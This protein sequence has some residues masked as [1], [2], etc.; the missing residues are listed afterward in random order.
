MSESIAG[1]TGGL[2]IRGARTHNLKNIDLDLPANALIV[3]TGVSGSGK[4]SLA[5]DTV[6]AEGQRRYVESL[7]AY[8]RQF[9]ERMEKPDVDEI[10][11]VSPAIAIRQKNSIRNPRSTVGTTTE[12]HDYLRLLYARVGRTFCRQCGQEVVRESA[13]VVARRLAALPEGTRLIIGFDM[14]VVAGPKAGADNGADPADEVTEAVPP[15]AN[16]RP[17]R[18]TRA[19]ARPTRPEMRP[20]FREPMGARHGPGVGHDRR[21]PPQGVRPAAHRDGRAAVSFDEVEPSL[22]GNRALLQVVVDRLVAGP[23]VLTRLTDSIETAYGEGGGAAFA[24]EL[25]PE[26]RRRLH[27]FSERFECRACGIAYE[28]P[29][30]RLFSFNNPFGACPT[31]HGFGNVIELD[32]DLVVPDPSRSINDNAIEPWSKPHYRSSLADL[33]RAARKQGV[34]LDVPWADL[35]EDERRFVVEGDGEDYEGDPRLLRLAGAEEVQ[36][37][38]PRVPEP[39]PRLPDVPGLRR[40]AAA[41]RGA[42]RARRRPDDRPGVRADRARGAALL[43]GAVA[44]R[45]GGGHRRRRCSP[46]SAAAWRSSPRSASTTSRS[47]AC[48][49]RSRAASRSASTW[50]PRSARRWSARCTCWTSRRSASTRATTCA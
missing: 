41:A 2:V 17:V 37:P 18:R 9:L 16:R 13:E 7:S 14:P 34:R 50:P 27:V 43:P 38:R 28:D 25:P 39:V 31:C 15:T 36:G 12:I 5:F 8:A 24:V 1:A 30:P 48:R 10:D 32:M 44:G 33:K 22:L 42:R 19:R 35:T 45:A 6:Y 47:I 20:P 3:V 49:P 4:S 23:D 21:A 46:R 40:R 29:Q 26:K 11:G